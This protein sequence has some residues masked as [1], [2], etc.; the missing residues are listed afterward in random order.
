MV[1]NTARRR[2]PPR[3][4]RSKAAPSS[5]C[6]KAICRSSTRPTM[7]HRRLSPLR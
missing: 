1:E 4:C 3:R 7:R 2:S 5:I 6:R